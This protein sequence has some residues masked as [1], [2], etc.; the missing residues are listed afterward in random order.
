VNRIALAALATMLAFPAAAAAI[1]WRS[2][3][4][5]S[6]PLASK[7]YYLGQD[8]A[9]DAFGAELPTV[10][11]VRVAIIDSGVDGSHP[12]F[13]KARIWAGRS[14]VGGR[15]DV[16]EQGH[17]TF[18]AGVIAAALNTQGIAGIAFPAQLI[19]AK[20]AR[21][22]QS[23][24]VED[25]AAAIRW[26]ADRGA[27]VINLSIGGLRDPLNPKRDTFSRAEANALEYA[28]RR[29]AV[30]VAA[31]GN[32]D[33]A[34]TS[35]WPYGSYPAALPHVLG[36]SALTPA[37]N[38]P[39]FSNRDLI[40][41]DISAPGQDIYST[42][43]VALTAQ[44]PG[45]V[46]QGYSDCGPE[47]FRHASGTSFAA[48][49]VTAA[50]A[51]LL[52]LRPSLTRDQIMNLLEHTATDVNASN[53]CRQCALLRDPLSGWGRL[54]IGRAVAALDGPLPPADRLEPN[55]DAGTHAAFLPRAVSTLHATVDFWDDQIDVY[56][57]R[58]EK[59]ERLVLDLDGPKGT[60][61]NLLLWR[62]GTKR[63]GDLRGQGMRVAQAIRPGSSQ[64]LSYRAPRAG[65]FYAEVK[66]ATRGS[67]S[68]ALSITRRK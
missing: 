39:T 17:G 59:R 30:L 54:D 36:V 4:V 13:P 52:G 21:G 19:I 29:G 9:F 18:V 32:G 16:D 63:V 68:Y 26:A 35:P 57:L 28:Y 8:H 65:M 58:L 50:A 55:D 7:Q 48:P 40:Y 24:S 64:R 61:V 6:D 33:E 25:E 42:L 15:W 46:N 67:G 34:P 53:G 43:P 20:I 66:L 5:P 12:E 27:Q 41:N 49:Q 44:R 37:G 38:V 3:F 14:F 56:R 2:G 47:E 23:I 10:N 51:V 1:P 60:N 31:I 22:D 62:P 11:P 45:C